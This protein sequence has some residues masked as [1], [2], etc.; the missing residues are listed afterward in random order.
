[1]PGIFLRKGDGELVR[2]RDEL[3]ESEDQLQ[4]LLEDHP[5]LLLGETTESEALAEYMLVQREAGVPVAGGGPDRWLLDH[6]FLDRQ[7]VPTLVEVKRST[8]TRV[9]REVV[10]QMLDYAA[11][12]LAHWPLGRMRDEFEARCE[13]AD[14]PVDPVRKVQQLSGADYDDY[15]TR[16]KTNLAA[17][18]LRLV[19]VADH[20]PA[21]L[22]T[23]VEFLNEQMQA[24]EVLA[25]EVKQHPGDGL[26]V[27][28]TQVIGQTS[29]ARHTKA[30]AERREWNTELALEELRRTSPEAV[31]VA[32]QLLHWAQDRGLHIWWGSG[33]KVGYGSVVISSPDGVNARPFGLSTD[34]K[35]DL[36]PPQIRLLPPFDRDGVRLDFLRRIGAAA[37]VPV[38][39]AVADQSFKSFPLETLALPERYEAA[40]SALDWFVGQTAAAA[41]DPGA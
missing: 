29:A 6:I 20:I 26:T 11:N 30:V 31:T 33:A 7:G 24:A 23:I 5:E 1:M 22:Q 38:A 41:T 28:T 8:D 14:P 34:G 39:D 21:T 3:Y 27:L 36:Y 25:V 18:R 16:V 37:E 40:V 35:L 32:E 4:A 9:R 12:I 17:K 13:H 15:W 2:L 10:G 19:F